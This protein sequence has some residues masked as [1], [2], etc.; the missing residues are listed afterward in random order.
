MRFNI[1]KNIYQYF[2]IPYLT[3]SNNIWQH[4][5]VPLSNI[6]LTIIGWYLTIFDFK[7]PVMVLSDSVKGKSL[8]WKEVKISSPEIA[9]WLSDS[10]VRR[11]RKSTDYKFQ[12]MLKNWLN[13][14]VKLFC[15]LPSN[16]IPEQR[17]LKILS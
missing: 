5:S 6:T 17:Q 15:F 13:F 10:K 16:F 12:V 9:R 11:N 2:T 14:T 7:F 1:S 3:I 8:A 4:L